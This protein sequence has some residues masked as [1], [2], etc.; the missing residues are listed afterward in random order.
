MPDK[1]LTPVQ[2][3][4]L[5][6][7]MA[8][9]RELANVELTGR[10]RLKLEKGQ[11]DTLKRRE[12]IRTRTENRRVYLELGDAGWTWCES[13]FSAEV[14]Q[15]AGH[16]G[17][18]AYALLAS[19]WRYTQHQ[20][21]ELSEFFVRIEPVNLEDQ[22]RQAYT[23]LAAPGEQVRLVDLRPLIGG[24]NSDQSAVDAALV[25]MSRLA[26]VHVYPESRQSALQDNDRAAA[27]TIGN[28]A[29]HLIVID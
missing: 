27:V 4:V 5:L 20:Q 6:V 19:I 26:D 22:I 14:P 15:G 24:G 9:G 18:A 10:Y 17:A 29:N 21:V 3:S 1:D 2:R 11:R 23:K 25:A 13:Q 8:E 16:G 7:L 28:Q 12:L